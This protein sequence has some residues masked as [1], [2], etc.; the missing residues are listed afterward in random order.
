MSETAIAFP[1]TGRASVETPVA[2]AGAGRASTETPVAYAGE[3]R[4]FL[5]RFSGAEVMPVS[6]VR[7]W[8]CAVVLLVSS[9]PRHSCPCAKKFARRLC[10]IAKV[11]KSSPSALKMA[12]IQRFYTCWASFFAEM[13]VEGRRWASFFAPTGAV[14]RSCRRCGALQGGFDGVLRHAKPSNG[15]SPA[16]RRLGWRHFPRLVTVNSQFAVVSWPNCRPIGGKE[17]KNDCFG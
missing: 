17:S 12:Q 1:G 8:G 16:C 4:A 6:A 14:A 7:C 9:L 3:K 2:F 13:P 11:R 5:A 15:V 10:V